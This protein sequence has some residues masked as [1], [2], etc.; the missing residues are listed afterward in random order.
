MHTWMTVVV[1][2]A[3]VYHARNIHCEIFS[4]IDELE[5]LALD[6][7]L[8]FEQVEALLQ[9]EDDCYVKR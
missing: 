5:N 6:E 7:V 2:I 8:I 4:A 3:V 1:T 9:T